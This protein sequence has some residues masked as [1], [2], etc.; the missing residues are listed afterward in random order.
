MTFLARLA[1]GFSLLAVFHLSGHAKGFAAGLAADPKRSAAFCLGGLTP[2]ADQL[3]VRFIRFVWFLTAS[4]LG[5]MRLLIWPPLFG[6]RRGL[7]L[8]GHASYVRASLLG[9]RPAALVLRLGRLD[10]GR[11]L[12]LHSRGRRHAFRWFCAPGRGGF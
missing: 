5:R 11:C 10:L 9:R 1:I 7:A 8:H 12:T 3:I 6:A 2:D 4:I